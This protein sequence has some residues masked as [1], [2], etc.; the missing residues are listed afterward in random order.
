M[1]E[2]RKRPVQSSRRKRTRKPQNKRRRERSLAFKAIFSGLGIIGIFIAAFLWN[3]YSP[4]EDEVNLNEYYGIENE[5]QVALVINNEV[6]ESKGKIEEGK[7]YIQ[8]ETLRDKINSRFYWDPNENLLLYTL[9]N[10][11]VTVPVGS[12]DYTVS[13]EKN[14]EDY[15]ILKTE[16]STAYIALDFIKKY[17]N[18]AYEIYK[19][20]DRAVIETDW[21]N[22]MA[23]A[24][25]DTQIRYQAGIKSPVLSQ[26]KKSSKVV[27]IEEEGDWEKVKTEDGFIGYIKQS[28]LSKGEDQAAPE[29]YLEPEYTSISKDYTINMAWHNVTNEVANGN[30]LETIA[31]TKGLNTISPTWFHVGDVSGTLQSIASSQYVNYCHQSGIEVWAAIRDFDGGINSYEESFELLRYTSRR[32]NLISQLIGAALQSGIDGINLDFEKISEECGEHY[33]QFVRELSV[34]CRQNG[35]VFS[36]DN[37]VP[38]G[39]NAHYN[40]KEQGVFADYVVIM[41]YDEH[42]GGSPEAGSVASYSFVKD[43]IEETMKEVPAEKIISGMPFFTRLWSETPKTAEE[44]SAGKGTDGENYSVNVTSEALGMVAAQSVLTQNGIE[45]AWDDEMKQYYASWTIENTTYRIWM[46]NEASLEEKLKLMKENNLAGCAF[47]ALGQEDSNI[48]NLV[49]KYVN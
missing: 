35:L 7:T 24:K 27:L 49:V 8:Y 29:G 15:T 18:M 16:G 26:V 23:K 3:R 13:K 9:P 2:R 47:W 36:I 22:Q 33:I 38:K 43:G 20:P 46:E 44:I 30:V 19:D 48:W 40:R 37:Y 14:S 1:E 31:S 6:V 41:G 5:G 10:D 12:K 17:T 21:S 42:W 39:F 4:S 28:Q 34:R 11:I 25:K 45:A 32:E